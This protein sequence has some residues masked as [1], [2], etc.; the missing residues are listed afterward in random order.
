MT[1]FSDWRLGDD[2]RV[3]PILRDCLR[4]A[5]AAPSIHNTQPWRFRIRTN[6]IDVFVD[7]TRRLGVI[8]PSG[9]EVLISVG[10]ALLNLRVAIL[11]HGRA[12]LT[13]LIP[14]SDEP[15]HVAQVIFGPPTPVSDTVRMLAQAIPRR[16]TNRRPFAEAAVPP[17]VLHELVD[18]ATV[19]GSHLA[20][21]DPGA[22]EAV[23]SLVRLA[24]RRER[25]EP[26]YWRELQ[27]WT[28]PSPDRRDGVPPEAYG[29]WSAMEAVPIRDFGLIEPAR[30][31]QV[32][33]FETEP[34]IAV[35]YSTGDSARQWVIT[36]QALERTLLTATVRGVATTLMTQPLEIPELRELLSDSAA[37][38]IP[39]AIVRFG[40]GPTSAPTPRRPLEEVVDG[41]TPTAATYRVAG[42]HR[43]NRDSP[44]GV[45]GQGGGLVER[46]SR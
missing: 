46:T 24:E 26:A 11:A 30:R 1:G 7:Q 15:D 35:L 18:A 23:L 38:L 36:G 44:A 45:T 42:S 22:R 6:G 2:G 39:Q 19:E 43:S 34:T 33:V 27:K 5:I 8:D 28:A 10:A 29:P 41:L 4:A 13:G 17:E 20:V 12:P 32:E 9:R 14:D 16:H 37:G 31:R 40:Y 3:G 25:G 21:A